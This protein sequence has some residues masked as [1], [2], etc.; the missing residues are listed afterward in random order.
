M[1]GLSAAFGRVVLAGTR[2]P[3]PS[4]TAQTL[5]MPSNMSAYT[6]ATAI[7]G[8]GMQ[9][10]TP[11]GQGRVHVPGPKRNALGSPSRSAPPTVRWPANALF[12]APRTGLWCTNGGYWS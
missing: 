1:T 6:P 8:L 7:H 10:L 4:V 12:D 3:A 11:E 9:L 5:P 2:L